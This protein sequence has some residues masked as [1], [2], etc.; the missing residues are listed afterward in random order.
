[1]IGEDEIKNSK[2][3]IKDNVT[4]EQVKISKENIIEYLLT[5]Y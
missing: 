5:Y 2:F 4:K 3:T 1:M